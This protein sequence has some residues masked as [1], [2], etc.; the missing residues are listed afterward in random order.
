[1]LIRPK[2]FENLIIYN[3]LATLN[4]WGAWRREH[5][6]MYFSIVPNNVYAKFGADMSN[7]IETI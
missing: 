4:N 2:I 6:H 5:T 3:S 1:M 7:D